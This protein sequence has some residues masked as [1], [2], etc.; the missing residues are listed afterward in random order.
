M[1]T[2]VAFVR[3]SDDVRRAASLMSSRRIGFIPVCSDERK[4][5]GVLTDRDIAVRCVAKGKPPTTPVREVMTRE[6]IACKPDD[7][8]RAA[9]IAMIRHQRRRVVCL[10]EHQYLLGVISLSDLP[11]AGRKDEA[12]MVLEHVSKHEAPHPRW[13]LR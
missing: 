6:I 8:I 5:V 10:G 7:D 13:G 9:E 12:E 11:R 3:P 1:Q 2:D 4:V